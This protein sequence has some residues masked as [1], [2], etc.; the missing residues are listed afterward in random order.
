M[1]QGTVT[2]ILAIER[3]TKPI[4]SNKQMLVSYV[5]YLSHKYVLNHA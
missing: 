2:A 5:S 1:F 4:E 3:N